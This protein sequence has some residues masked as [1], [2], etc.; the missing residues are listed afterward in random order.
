MNAQKNTRGCIAFAAAVVASLVVAGPVA[1]TPVMDDEANRPAREAEDIG[2]TTDLGISTTALPL[3]RNTDAMWSGGNA[4]NATRQ[5]FV[6]EPGTLGL[7]GLGLL[8]VAVS[9]R[10]TSRRRR[11]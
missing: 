5:S 10:L 6:I 2:R 8:G 1:A 4:G 3:R 11:D 9:R 7:V